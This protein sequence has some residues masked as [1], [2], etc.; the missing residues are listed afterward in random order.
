M[1]HK[2]LQVP[3]PHPA[4]VLVQSPHTHPQLLLGLA[5]GQVGQG[6]G[7]GSLETK[8]EAPLCLPAGVPGVAWRAVVKPYS[9]LGM[10][11]GV[12]PKGL[13]ENVFKT[14]KLW[15]FACGNLS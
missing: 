7:R 9:V 13:L 1:G 10:E 3:V 8:L 14:I 5:H 4:L 2:S 12:G 11:G 6:T 15:T